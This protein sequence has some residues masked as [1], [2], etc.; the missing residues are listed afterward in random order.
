MTTSKNYWR[1]R[2]EKQRQI[3]VE[4]DAD[5]TKRMDEIYRKCIEELEAQL[6]AW[7]IKY[8][9]QNGMSMAQ[10]KKLA[11][12]IDIR[13][14]AK[15]AKK[16]VAEKDFSDE[17]NAQMKI[18]NLTMKSNR[19]DLIMANMNAEMVV[20]TSEIEDIMEQEIAGRGYEEIER[21]AGILGDTVRNTE[22]AVK[23]IAGASF[24][25]ATWSERLWKNQDSVR[26]IVSKTMT[27][28]LVK[29]M[30]TNDAVKK[31]EKELNKTV[32]NASYCARRLVVTER[33]RVAKQVQMQ[34]Y[35][36]CGV[37]W[38][39][40]ITEPGCC[41]VC[42]D[43]DGKKFKVGNGEAGINLPPEHPNCVLPD[44]K[45]IA[46]DMDAITRSW[47]SGPVVK[48]KLSNSTGL[49]V[50]PNHIMATTR[51][52]VRAQD[53][54]EGDKIIN[55]CGWVKDGSPVNPADCDGVP[56]IEN[57]FTSLVESGLVS[58]TRVPATSVDLKGDVVEN[59][60]INI[61]FVD[62]FLRDKINASLSQFICD[63]SLISTGKG[64]ENPLSC[65]GTL[66]KFLVGTGLTLDGIMSG[67]SVSAVLLGSSLTH[68]QLVGLRTPS[69]YDARLLKCSGDYRTADSVTLGNGVDTLSGSV[70]LT[71]FGSVKVIP[72]DSLG[73]DSVLSA[74]LTDGSGLKSESISDF[75]ISFPGLVET[76]DVTSVVFDEYSG[77]VYDISTLSTLYT[78]NSLLSSN[79]R[80]SVTM[81]NDPTSDDPFDKWLETFDEHEMNYSDW[82]EENGYDEE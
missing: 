22:P 18:Y 19:L 8:A 60:E 75:L 33:Q 46:P 41:E 12:A 37:E 17:A 67:A 78:C 66:A 15:L 57:L 28:Y 34:V 35:K 10:A 74:E 40:Y 26:Q 77:H 16:Y 45:I 27:D 25:S 30:P 29:G 79:C 2:E 82:L 39:Q 24:Q 59:T 1:E 49:T 47:Y 21:Q 43:L 71:D 23:T 62:S 44:T 5:I 42:A 50:T 70:E 55:Y 63:S 61:V 64:C 13:K 53:I 81:A 4:N 11:D 3:D 52:W 20:R 6:N 38:Y 69:D 31:L 7:Y 51:G 76:L 9:D 65:D 14:Y 36:D 68:H 72:D 73:C 32:S 58:S 56:T 80:C 54:V 48:F